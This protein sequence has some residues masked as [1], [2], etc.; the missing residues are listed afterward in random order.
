MR[1]SC[2]VGLILL[3]ACSRKEQP[4]P[5]ALPV[6]KEAVTTQSATLEIKPAA[7][8]EEAPKPK[9]PRSLAGKKVLHIGDSMV[10]GNFGLTRAL[11]AKLSAE[12]AKIVRHTTVSESLVSFD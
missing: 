1:R 6:P 10:G 11:E 2:F 8:P 9:G 3:V 4:T 12:N 7:P 5:E